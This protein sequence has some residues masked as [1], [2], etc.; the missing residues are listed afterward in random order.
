MESGSPVL[1]ALGLTLLGLP[2]FWLAR[3]PALNIL[4]LF[5]TGLG[6]ANQY[7]LTMSIAVGI[8]GEKTNQASARVTLAVGT[9]LLTAPLV[10]GRLADS[11]GLQKAFGM[12][13]ILMTTAVIVVIVNNR[14]LLQKQN[15]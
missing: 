12:V 9:A 10:L 1:L 8:A 7:P 13:L 6:I 11:L 14:F 15:A 4:G 2:L 5:I 3:T